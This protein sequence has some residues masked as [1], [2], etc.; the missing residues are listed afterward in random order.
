M[1]QNMGLNVSRGYI[2]GVWGVYDA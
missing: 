1:V 2:D